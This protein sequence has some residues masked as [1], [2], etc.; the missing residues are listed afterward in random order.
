M[1][2]F[3]NTKPRMQAVQHTPSVIQKAEERQWVQQQTKNG[4][5]NNFSHYLV[6]KTFLLLSVCNCIVGST[7][8]L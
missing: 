6:V 5:N 1:K 8:L 7:A 2:I 4:K 3:V